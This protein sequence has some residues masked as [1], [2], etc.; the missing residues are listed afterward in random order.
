MG[1]PTSHFQTFSVFN[2]RT[3]KW[4]K[5]F[6]GRTLLS[7][8]TSIWIACSS[9]LKSAPGYPEEALISIV[10]HHHRVV[11]GY[12]SYLSLVC[13]SLW[14]TMS[15]STWTAFYRS[16]RIKKIAKWKNSF[17]PDHI[18]AATVCWSKCKWG[19]EPM[20]ASPQGRQHDRQKYC[21]FAMLLSCVLPR[22]FSFLH[23]KKTLKRL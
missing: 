16:R 14:H 6:S 21:T 15:I 2:S 1:N 11:I 7:L 20:A 22:I 19:R 5:T 23:I 13:K 4:R 9:A 10:A 8:N 17:W 18:T 12:F 3:D